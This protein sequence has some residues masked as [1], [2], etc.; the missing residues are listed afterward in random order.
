[1]DKVRYH[2][3]DA[4]YILNGSLSLSLHNFSFVANKGYP[5]LQVF[6]S[7]AF[8][9]FLN[10]KRFSSLSVFSFSMPK[11]AMVLIMLI[12]NS[13]FFVKLQVIMFILPQATSKKKQI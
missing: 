9:L 12:F 10:S 8:G 11:R 4:S 6:F 5:Q 1:V 3:C 13:E 7:F 2:L